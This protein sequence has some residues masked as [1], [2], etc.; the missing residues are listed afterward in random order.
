MNSYGRKSIA[1]QRNNAQREA[2]KQIAEL[3]ASRLQL[4]QKEKRAAPKE[5]SSSSNAV[6]MRALER[7]VLMLQLI[8]SGAL[9]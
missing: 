2:E 4:D 9:H 7:V 8:S 3:E 1:F 6:R 5:R